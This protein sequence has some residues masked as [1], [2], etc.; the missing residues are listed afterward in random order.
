MQIPSI[1]QDD[2]LD[3]MEMTNK[4]ER[5]IENVLK[6]NDLTLAMSALMSATINCTIAQC[7]DIDEVI[8]YRNILS[9]IFDSSIKSIK[10]K[11]K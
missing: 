7:K 9:E 5:F 8:F 6:E 10:L 4:L 11:K 2:L 3:V 1:P